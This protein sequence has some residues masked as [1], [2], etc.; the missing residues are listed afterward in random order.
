MYIFQTYQNVTLCLR[1]Y[2]NVLAIN[3]DLMSLKNYVNYSIESMTQLTARPAMR[4]ILRQAQNCRESK[5]E[6]LQ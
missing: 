5:C 3:K 4:G 2:N 1:F 6:E